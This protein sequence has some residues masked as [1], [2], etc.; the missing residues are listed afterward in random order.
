MSRESPVAN[1]AKDI[2]TQNRPW[3]ANRRLT[4]RT[5]RAVM[6]RTFSIRALHQPAHHLPRTFQRENRVPTMIAD[7]HLAATLLARTIFHVQQYPNKL[8]SFRPTMRHRLRGYPN[9]A[10]GVNRDFSHV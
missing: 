8:R 10:I 6:A 4:L 3:Q 7:M 9:T 1:P 5:H 2:P